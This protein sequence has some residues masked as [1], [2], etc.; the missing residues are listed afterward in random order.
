MIRRRQ[1][2]FRNIGELFIRTWNNVDFGYWRDRETIF[3]LLIAEKGLEGT[4][5]CK[6][7]DW[8]WGQKKK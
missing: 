8:C 6:R 1:V 2:E 5:R 3:E 4:L 7:R